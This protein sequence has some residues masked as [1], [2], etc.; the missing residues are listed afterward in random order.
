VAELQRLWGQTMSNQLL[1]NEEIQGRIGIKGH[2]LS[3]KT[4]NDEALSHK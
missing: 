2:R 3:K 4:S 1:V